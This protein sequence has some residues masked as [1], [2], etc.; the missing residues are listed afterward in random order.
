MRYV[1]AVLIGCHGLAHLA[2][3]GVAFQLLVSLE[4]PY[5]T[6][7]LNGLVD[8][9]HHGARI[10][11]VLWLATALACMFAGSALWENAAWAAP[12]TTSVLLFSLALCVA[13]LPEAWLGVLANVVLLAPFLIPGVA[14][15]LRLS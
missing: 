15:S 6:T 14:S 12:F 2:G 13:A 7:V 8:V 1:I 4:R 9:G 5:Q 3:F 10:V 11:G